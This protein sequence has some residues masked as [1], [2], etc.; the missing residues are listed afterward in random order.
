MQ[1]YYNGLC[2]LWR[3]HR[4]SLSGAVRTPSITD[5]AAELVYRMSICALSMFDACV[6][7]FLTIDQSFKKQEE[8][9]ITYYF[10]EQRAKNAIF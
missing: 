10:T 4:I 7:T 3:Q 1:I 8:T 2:I 9:Q 5:E 6:R